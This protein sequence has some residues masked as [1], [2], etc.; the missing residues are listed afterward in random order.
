MTSS[1][2]SERLLV[3]A[4][5][6][7]DAELAASALRDGGLESAVCR[8]PAELVTEI[9]AGAGGVVLA[10]E[11][12]SGGEAEALLAGWVA[13]QPPWSD[14]PVVVIT[15]ARGP[16]ELR[17][18]VLSRLAPLGNVILLD[19]PLRR[20]ALVSAARTAVRARR[21]QYAARAV[22]VAQEEAVRS[23][24]QFLAML[25]HELRNPLSAITLATHVMQREGSAP[26]RQLG[27]VDRQVR[28]LSRLVDDL[29]DV[30]RVTSG[31]IALELRR[32]DLSEL[33]AHSAET[34]EPL[35]AARELTLC[36]QPAGVPLPVRA[37]AARLEQVLANLLGNALKYTPR[38]GHVEVVATVEG[39]HAVVKVRDDGIGI[40]PEHLPRVFDLFMQVETTL[41][42]AQGG[43]GLGLTLA[44]N[45]VRMHGG[46]LQAQSEGT[47]R[48]TEMAVRLPL[49]D[50]PR[51]LERG[52]RSS[53][54]APRSRRVLVVDDGEDN[55]EVLAMCLEQLGHEVLVAP[56]GPSAVARAL[57]EQLDL[58]LVDI[59]LPGLDGYEVARRVRAARGP[60]LY[61]V[62][63]TG[64]GQPEDRRRALDAG[65]DQ[66]LTKPVRVS[67][68]EDVLRCVGRPGRE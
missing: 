21:R 30:S 24:D 51:G 8:E 12:L 59:G 38:G 34:F 35:A 13:H 16:L 37:D 7:R 4:P 31:K 45:L 67:A 20:V 32:L 58:M 17:G 11:V 39:E 57:S 27:V 14:L 19:R 50:E 36:F 3:L 49:A 10:E 46:T 43:L 9:A 18:Q 64:Y 48:G 68:L 61:M 26:A 54:P 42:R 2:D 41:D 33:V 28:Q 5:T 52:G 56:D 55:R 66:H 15:A 29:L 23:R 40:A 53:A 22:L 6:G 65:F 44:Q 1:P 47:D 63:L 62:A 25:G 60:G